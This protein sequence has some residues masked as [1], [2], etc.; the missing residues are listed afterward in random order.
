LA[1]KRFKNAQN[2][3]NKIHVIHVFA[4][5]CT[6]KHFMIDHFLY[7]KNKGYE[8]NMIC[9]DD[10]E[11]KYVKKTAE[12]N[13]IPVTIKQQISPFSDIVSLLKL[14]R[15]FRKIRP[16]IVDSHMSK[17]GLLGT[18]AAW[19]AMV[20]IRIYHNHGM[21]LLSSSGIK[22]WT[23]YFVELVTCVL[24]T[25]VFYV[26]PSNKR[27]VIKKG[28][29]SEKKAAVL[30]PGTICGVDLTKYDIE[31]AG[32]NSIELRKQAGIPCDSRIVGFVAR[33]V[34]HKGIETIIEAWKKL[35]K[36]IRDK[37][38]LCLFGSFDHKGMQLLVERAVADEQLHIKY[39]GFTNDLPEWYSTMDLLVQPSWH[40]G[41]GYN[42]L[43]AA[44]FEVPSIGTNISA[45]EDAIQNGRTGILVPV[46]DS[47]V[48][49][50]EIARLLNDEELRKTLGKNARKRTANEFDKERI[51]P[52]LSQKYEE[53]LKKRELTRF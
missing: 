21:A 24:A 49:S 33:I 22:Y 32:Q 43:E 42:V 18:F 16:D 44:C 14:W 31:K 47:D 8:V 11:A 46:K 38:Y 9:S 39:M 19:L 4:R 45:T 25:E 51:V 52:L 35:P 7:L 36:N 30:G 50:K 27:D 6:P 37:C 1:I 3:N 41:W 12:I 48:M 40:E 15:V 26:S 17:A 20:P 29:C 53:L 28:I 2:I 23:L 5:G 34:P 13:F 10:Q